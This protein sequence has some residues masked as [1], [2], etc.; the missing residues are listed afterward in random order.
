MLPC[1]VVVMVADRA[2]VH[3]LHDALLPA[4]E[5]G[6]L[7]SLRLIGDADAPNL[8]AQAV[9]SGHLAA[10]EHGEELDRDA[11]PFRRERFSVPR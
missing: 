6:R 11:V 10:R 8:I 3:D 5:D 2:P 9:F 1:D 7:D 4:L